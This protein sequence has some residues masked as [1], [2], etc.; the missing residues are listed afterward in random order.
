MQIGIFHFN[1][2]RNKRGQFIK[3]ERNSWT[4]EHYINHK[5]SFNKYKGENHWNWKGNNVGYAS[6]HEWLYKNYGKPNVCEK[7]GGLKNIVWANKKGNYTRERKEWLQ[8]C[9]SCHK[10]YDK[11]IFNINKMKTVGI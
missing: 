1:I 8:L 7:C 4:R 11:I 3:G 6:L 5:K 10:K 9:E 2:M